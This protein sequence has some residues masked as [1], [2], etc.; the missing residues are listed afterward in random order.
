MSLHQRKSSIRRSRFKVFKEKILRYIKIAS[1]YRRRSVCLLPF[2][3]V[4]EKQAQCK[5]ARK[6]QYSSPGFKRSRP[7]DLSDLDKSR[8]RITR[9][10]PTYRWRESFVRCA[11]LLSHGFVNAWGRPGQAREGGAVLGLIFAGYVPL[12]SQSPY[13]II[14]YFVAYYRSHLSHF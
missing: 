13:P 6:V 14:V 9:D 8:I 12:A 10:W 11:F 7:A 3:R 4:T 5:E 1:T 2:F